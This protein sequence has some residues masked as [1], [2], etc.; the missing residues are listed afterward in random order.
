MHRKSFSQTCGKEMK[1]HTKQF[2]LIELLV[3][4]AITA[5]LA[6]LI[7]PVLNSARIRAK[8]IQCMNNLKQIGIALH[9]YH[10]EYDSLPYYNLNFYPN[11]LGREGNYGLSDAL[12]RVAGNSKDIFFCPAGTKKASTDWPT[13]TGYVQ[14]SYYFPCLIHASRWE[15]AGYQRPT[16]KFKKLDPDP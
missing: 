14:S 6:G 4:I 9:I 13:P 11:R 5:I 12:L 1:K 2:T 8:R 15:A 3:V 10:N 16:L 7:L